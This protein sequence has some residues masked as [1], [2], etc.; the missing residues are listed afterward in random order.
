MTRALLFH[1][2]ALLRAVGP[3][4]ALMLVGWTLL[5]ETAKAGGFYRVAECSPGHTGTPDAKVDGTSPAF[6]A[7]TSCAGGNWLQVQSA[8]AAPA[9]AAKQ[10]TYTAPSGTRIREFKT[11]YALIG[12]PVPDGNRSFLFVR[13]QGQTEQENLSVVGLGSTAGTFDSALQDQG[14]LTA[15]GVG[16]FCSKAAG[17]CSYAPSQLARMSKTSFLIEDVVPPNPPVVAG[18]GVDGAWV[19][20]TTQLAVGDTDTGGGVHRTT[21]AVA[22]QQVVSDTV[23]DPQN[24]DGLVSSMAPCDAIELRYLALDTTSPGFDEGPGNEIRVCTHEF[25]FGAASTCT[26]KTLNVDNVAPIRPQ[27]LEIA[28]GEGWRHDNDFDLSWDNPEQAHAPIAAA[29]VRVTG[30][31]G[32][33]ASVTRTGEGIDSLDDVTVPGPGSY[34]A[35]VFLRDAAGNESPLN[36]ATVQ[37]R[38]DDTVPAVSRPEK[39]NGWLSRSQVGGRLCADLAASAGSGS[40]TLRD[41]RLPRRGQH[42]PES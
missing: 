11:D 36:S 25:G 40:T 10:W 26:T 20:G 1:L 4:I 6:S 13:R 5:P 39:A 22:G 35:D 33:E 7:S 12:D 24:S 37:L 2:P 3:C 30:P 18:V 32:Y 8:A 34:T 27:S 15:V 41:R 28:G 42:R 16:V 21:V 38:F 9:G 31:N 17:T 23:C 14:P 19:G 29:T